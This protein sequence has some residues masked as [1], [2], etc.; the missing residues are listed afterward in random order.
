MSLAPFCICDLPS[1]YVPDLS[2]DIPARSCNASNIVE[3]TLTTEGD[4][5]L[6][7]LSPPAVDLPAWRH[8]IQP[9]PLKTFIV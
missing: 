5:P 7:V 3:L 2:P 1:S 4:P 9:K 6:D 8:Q